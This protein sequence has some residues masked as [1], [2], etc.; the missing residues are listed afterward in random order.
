MK[1]GPHNVLFPITNFITIRN[2]SIV[3][4]I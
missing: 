4:M 3:F 1:K 2:H